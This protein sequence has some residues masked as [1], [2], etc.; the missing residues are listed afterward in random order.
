MHLS[1]RGQKRSPRHDSIMSTQ[2]TIQDFLSGTLPPIPIPHSSFAHSSRD[3]RRNVG[4]PRKSEKGLPSRGPTPR[5]RPVVQPSGAALSTSA[6][7]STAHCGS[8]LAESQRKN[9][10]LPQVRLVDEK[11]IGESAKA[12]QTHAED[13][14]TTFQRRRREMIELVKGH[15][16]VN[17]HQE[18]YDAIHGAE[19]A[20]LY[21]PRAIDDDDFRPLQKSEDFDSRFMDIMALFMTK[22]VS[23]MMKQ[24]T[25]EI[26]KDSLQQLTRKL[27]EDQKVAELQ[28]QDSNKREKRR[29]RI[30]SF[31]GNAT[32][33]EQEKPAPSV[34]ELQKKAVYKSFRIMAH[35]HESSTASSGGDPE[36]GEQVNVERVVPHKRQHATAFAG[37]VSDDSCS[38][39]DDSVVIDE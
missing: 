29:S 11:G 4:T 28:K 23:R 19:D 3:P 24:G 5:V 13:L 25:N 17:V 21:I 39:G 8:I 18:D 34:E 15:C 7:S 9:F 10:P 32:A 2:Q 20:I 30:A 38:S 14:L 36:T 37:L 26:D 16:S 27:L 12:S 22:D 1:S 31:F 35:H 6:N 33:A